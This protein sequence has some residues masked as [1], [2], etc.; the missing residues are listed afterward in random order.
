MTVATGEKDDEGNPVTRPAKGAMT[1][2]D[3]M[4]HT[5][6][7]PTGISA[8]DR[9]ATPAAEVF[10][11]DQ[12]AIEQANLIASPPLEHGPGAT[13]DYSRSTDVPVAVGAAVSGQSLE[14]FRQARLFDPQRC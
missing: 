3:L 11:S 2:R 12:T 7:I 13:W 4:R 5:S 6:G 8:P 10:S 9:R 14:E 1:V